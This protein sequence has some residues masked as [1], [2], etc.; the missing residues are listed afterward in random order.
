MRLGRDAYGRKP[1]CKK[2]ISLGFIIIIGLM[3]LNLARDGG[4]HVSAPPHPRPWIH[5][6]YR[7]AEDV[8]FH[9]YQDT[10]LATTSLATTANTD[11]CLVH[12][13]IF[14]PSDSLPC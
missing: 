13:V 3:A 12:S 5:H 10:R 14:I 9:I 1:T 4:V 2:I 6:W 11:K 7:N 8:P